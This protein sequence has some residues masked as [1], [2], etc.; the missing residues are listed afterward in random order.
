MLSEITHQ[1]IVVFCTAYDNYALQAFD[2]FSIDY[3]LKPVEK[4]RIESTISKLEHLHR[5][6]PLSD[7]IKNLSNPVKKAYP[8]AI[9]HKIGD[10]I[11]LVKLSD[12]TYFE[13]D[14]KYVNFYNAGS[15]V[16]LTEQSLQ[17][18]EKKLP[19]EFIRISKSV[20]INSTAVMELHKYLRGKYILIVNDIQRTKIETGASYHNQ[21][22]E[23]FNL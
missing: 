18:L 3:L 16:F 6:K 9:P 20:I 2:N 23:K 21:I 10:K 4:E 14:N 7:L 19:P 15:K 5:D 1:P 8:T 13:A 17:N 22:K 11:I 12:I